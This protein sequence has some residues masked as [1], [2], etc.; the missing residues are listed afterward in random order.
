MQVADHTA[1]LYTIWV[2]LVFCLCTPFAVFAVDRCGRRA[3]LLGGG[4]G[5]TACL[6]GL[7][8]SFARLRQTS[9]ETAGVLPQLCIALLLGFVGCFS[10]SWGPIAWVVPS[11]LIGTRLRAKVIAIGTVANWL[12]DYAVVGTF[13]SLTKAIG[14]A[15][16]FA[17]YAGINA[18][19]VVFVYLLV[20]ETRGMA[21]E[22]A[23]R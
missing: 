18:A 2:G 6:V 12:A 10:V 16:S 13:L 3:L 14:E 5:M 15:G 19:A 22:E 20:P 17:L 23:A 7:A 21:L 9:A 4:G 11:E 1:A 8:A